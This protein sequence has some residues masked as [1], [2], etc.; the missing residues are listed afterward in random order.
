MAASYTEEERVLRDSIRRAFEDF[1]PE[2]VEEKIA[3]AS[4]GSRAIVPLAESLGLVDHFLENGSTLREL[5]IVAQEEGRVLLPALLFEKFAIHLLLRGTTA[6]QSLSVLRSN[7]L[8]GVF[9]PR[10]SDPESG[11]GAVQTVTYVQG[12]NNISSALQPP[13]DVRSSEWRI[14]EGSALTIIPCRNSLDPTLS[15]IALQVPRDQGTTVKLDPGASRAFYLL[16]LSAHVLGAAQRIYEMTCEYVSSRKQ[17][18]VSVG[19]F[20]AV[21]HSLAN[22]LRDLESLESLVLLSASMWA[23]SGP[24]EFTARAAFRHA[25]NTIIPSLEGC[26]QLHGGIGFTFEFPLHLYLRRCLFL[27]TRHRHEDSPQRILEMA[28]DISADREQL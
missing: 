4:E 9:L 10:G 28:Q 22:I 19:S 11:D 16:L 21:Q 25:K 23:A 8:E 26:L 12:N 27:L 7:A 17:F 14:I 18:G 13:Y 2:R 5:V 15:L 1:A 24:F 6:E 3:L 20:Q